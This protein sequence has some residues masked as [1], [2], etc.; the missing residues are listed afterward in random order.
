[1]AGKEE[2]S[3]LLNLYVCDREYSMEDIAKRLGYSPRHLLRVIQSIYGMSLAE[4]RNKQRCEEAKRLLRHTKKPMDAITAD[5]GFKSPVA[6]REFFKKHEGT[7][8]ADYRKKY[9]NRQEA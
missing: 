4:Y 9:A 6:M 5:V 8:P 7:T 2:F 1:M 3:V